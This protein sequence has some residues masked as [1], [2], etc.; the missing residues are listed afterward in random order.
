MIDVDRA[1]RA[2]REPRSLSKLRGREAG[3]GPAANLIVALSARNGLCVAGSSPFRKHIAIVAST[4]H[5]CSSKSFKFEQIM[6]RADQHPFLFDLVQPAQQELPDPA[7][8]LICPNTGS[9]VCLRSRYG[10]S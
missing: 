2:H 7:A 6:G 10:L 4:N 5:L 3:Y 1:K 9:T 8:C